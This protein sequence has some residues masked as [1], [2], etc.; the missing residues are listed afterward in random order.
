MATTR[1]SSTEKIAHLLQWAAEWKGDT[2]GESAWSYSLRLGGSHALLNGWMNDAK[3][4]SALGP[5]QQELIQSARQASRT[6]R[7]RNTAG[8]AGR[9][10]R[11]P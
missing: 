6:G 1:Y 4:M 2:R 11:V 7:E 5:A 9:R 10:T 3:L 8:E